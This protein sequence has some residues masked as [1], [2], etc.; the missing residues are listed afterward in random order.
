MMK[1]Q[2][3]ILLL[4][5]IGTM[6]TF[7]QLRT[8]GTDSERNAEYKKAIGLDTTVP[9]FD[10][11]KID[12]QV[13]GSRLANLL[14]HL[15]QN[16]NKDT[17]E[18][19]IAQILGE[20]NESLQHLYYKIK[21]M[22]FANASKQGDV[23]TVL[24]HVWP[25]KNIADVNQ[26]DLMFR[27]V[28]GV[29]DNQT[30]N[31]LFSY[32]SR[33]ID[34]QETFNLQEGGTPENSKAVVTNSIWDN[35]YM[36]AG[37]DM[38]LMFPHEHSVKDVFPNGKSFGINAAIGK[39][40]SPEFGGRVKLTWNNGIL[41]NDHNIW[42]APYGEPGQNH[43]EGGFVTFLGD[44]QFNLHNL[45]GRYRADRC[46]NLIVGPRFGGYLNIG[47]GYI[48]GAHVLG[49]GA[50]NT[51]RLSDLWRLFADLGYHFVSSI[52]GVSSGKGHGSN[53][54]A[55]IAVGV[56]MDLSPVNK[57]QRTSSYKKDSETKVVKV[58]SFWDN[59]FV[60]AGLGMSL[61]NPYGTN[62]ANVFPN[63]STYGVNL[64]IGK[65][66]TPMAG[67]RGGIN[68]QNGIIV[69]HHA[70]YLESNPEND[71]DPDKHSSGAIY[72]DM[73][74]N[75]H[76]LI[77]GY[78]ESRIWNAIIYPR[79]GIAQNFASSYK[80]N[81][82]LGLGTEQTFK[83]SNKMKLYADLTYHVVT[84]GFLDGKFDTGRDGCNGWFDLNVG[85]QYELGQVVGWDKPGKRPTS[86][87]VASSHNWPRFIVNTGVS[88]IVAF[89]VKT[90]LKKAIKEERPDHSDNKSFPSGHASMAFAA[91]RSIDKEFR[92]DCIWIPI[93][94]YAAATAIGVERVVNKHHHWYDVVAGA[95]IG[96]GSAELT[97][98]LSD[99]MF[100]KGS[101]IAFGSS[102][103]TV[104]VAI[105]L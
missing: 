54:F 84:G 38:N 10:T 20:Q 22:Q 50:V 82:I 91:A 24:M 98:W 4:L 7:S 5:F 100:G 83:L 21:K 78:D 32:M 2:L 6:N 80:E 86:S 105:T 13:M 44:I 85:V 88:V 11:N 95:G 60:Q 41:P 14:D 64:G 15:L 71:G 25:D 59:W 19:L 74:F 27:F 102:G 49:L 66:F 3:L 30:T 55:E 31:A 43:R 96:F 29:S 81:P 52:N 97:W 23:I 79:L 28:D 68:W 67:I 63:G 26:A 56:E 45:I 72:A 103:N 36:Q 48:S 101:N 70:S 46:W 33:Y 9:D 51:F 62:F 76:H 69:N 87:V 18:L 99:L 77:G 104:D 61:Q 17:Y 39:W 73:L 34:A 92:K 65:W 1:K 89:G 75:L 58:N 12:A 16:Y 94:G 8:V 37:V 90:V 57:F 40:F 53:G 42:L 93:A 47:K 35:W